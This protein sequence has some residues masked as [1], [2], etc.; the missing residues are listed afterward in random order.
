MV[1]WGQCW[2]SWV[3]HGPD[4]GELPALDA[5]TVCVCGERDALFPQ[6]VSLGTLVGVYILQVF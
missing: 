5:L 6:A 4:A 2:F 1:P 3:G